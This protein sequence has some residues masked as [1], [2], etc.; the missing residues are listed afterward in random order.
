[1]TESLKLREATPPFDSCNWAENNSTRKHHSPER[2]QFLF[3]FSQENSSVETEIYYSTSL[4]PRS[5]FGEM[6]IL[7][8]RQGILGRDAL[9]KVTQ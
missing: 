1:M 6:S 8:D 9:V 3:F 4:S 2:Q 7:L 5:I